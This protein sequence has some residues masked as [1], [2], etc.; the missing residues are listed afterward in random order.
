MKYCVL[1]LIF[2][3]LYFCIA[4][5]ES[6]IANIWMSWEL[7][8]LAEISIVKALLSNRFSLVMR[9]DENFA[10]RFLLRF[11][12]GYLLISQTGRFVH[13]FFCFVFN[14]GGIYPR[15]AP[16]KEARPNPFMLAWVTNVLTSPDLYME[17]V[18]NL[19]L[20]LVHVIR[21]FCL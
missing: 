11:N 8:L 19:V 7:L 20:E 14:W 3:P 15:R 9:I 17:L 4:T 2:G 1:R 21:K 6:Y 18:T 10:G 12:L 5:F 13:I 16:D